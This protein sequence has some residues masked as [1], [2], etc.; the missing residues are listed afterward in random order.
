MRSSLR[1]AFLLLIGL[2]LSPALRAQ[3]SVT[4]RMDGGRLF[5]DGRE[6]PRYLVNAPGRAHGQGTF[7][8]TGPAGSTLEVSGVRY[9]LS[10][11]GSLALD[12]RLDGAPD[13]VILPFRPHLLPASA[14]A[15]IAGSAVNAF[16]AQQEAA[17]EEQAL[18]LAA[19][20]STLGPG[21]ERTALVGQLRL[22][23][24][25]TFNVKQAL[26]AR[27]MAE[28]EAELRA[29]RQSWQRRQTQRDVLVE[30]R[31]VQLVG[32]GM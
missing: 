11:T 13:A 7:S 18:H 16:A 8:F 9:R 21:A 30:R 12:T 29:A 25:Q 5:V 31:L 28:I 27:E 19:E 26:R 4:F 15:F 10:G 17:L 23:L 22:H 32:S 14:V 24:A 6:E 2:A 1:L 20:I 3:V